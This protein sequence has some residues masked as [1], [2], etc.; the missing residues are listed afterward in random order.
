M[1]NPSDLENLLRNHHI[2]TTQWGIGEAKSVMDLWH[3]IH[4]GDSHLRTE[5]LL[6]VVQVVRVVICRE[7]QVLIEA[8]QEL[9]DG[10]RRM[11]Y[12]L[13]ADKMKPNETIQEAA[14]RCLVEELGLTP[15]EIQIL[16]HS[17]RKIREMDDSASYPGLPCDYTY[18]YVDANVTR[19]PATPFWVDNH[20]GKKDSVKRHHWVWVP[21]NRVK[22]IACI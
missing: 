8:E 21:A 20:G 13:P 18:H 3:E 9:M 22:L 15:Q 19:L 11:R 1:N 14:T 5:P 4:E 10:R 16:N 12:Q 7:D 17:Y 2:D 6:R